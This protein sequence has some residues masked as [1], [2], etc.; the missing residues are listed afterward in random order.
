MS[1]LTATEPII[2]ARLDKAAAKQY[3][4]GVLGLRAEPRWAGDSFEHK[5]VPVNVVACPSVL[6]IWEAIDSRNAD[7]WT[8]VLTDVDDDDLG[9]TVLAHLLDGRLIT[10]DPW[11]A[12]RGNFS[13]TTI[14]PALYRVANDRA[15]ANGLLAVLSPDSY[16]PA[17]G[18]VL[19]RDHAMTT[20]ARDV[21]KIV[22]DTGVEVDPLAILEWSRSADT[23]AHLADLRARGGADLF[24]ATAAWLGSR[25]GLLSQ[26]LTAL[27]A[28]GRINEL[29]PLGVVAGLFC[30]DDNTHAQALGMFLGR[31]GLTNLAPAGLQAWYTSAR[32]LVTTALKDPQT[33]LAAAASI[34]NEL[35]I[36]SAAATSDL[37]PQGLDARVAVLADALTEALPH[38]APTDPDAA[39]ITPA[40]R[41]NIET[42]W[43][44]VNR[45]FLA[46]GSL[47]VD[48]FAG[49]IRLVRWLA[50]PV[51]IATE[52]REATACYVIRDSW[53][54]TALTKA[55]RGAEQPVA[56]AAL[57]AVIDTVAARR[58]RHDRAFARA[59][60]DAHTPALPLIENVLREVVV[61]IARQTPTL[62]LVID[63]LSVA[64]ANDLVAAIQQDGWTEVSA[65][66]R[67]GSAL[68]V[69]PTLTQRSR[70]SLLCG[71]LREGA[72]DVERRGFLSLIR[73]THLEATGGG[74]DPIFHKAALDAIPSGASLATDVANAVADTDHRPLVAAV[75]NYVD[76]T[77]HHT[78][79]GGT[80]WTVGAITHLRALLGAARSAGRAVVITSDH[81]H[82]IEYGTSAKVNRAN[83]Y[84]QRAHGDFAHVDPGR[85]VVVEGPRVL[86]DTHKV[87]LAVDP[88]IRYGARNAGYHGG[89]APAEAIVPVLTFVAGQLPAWAHQVA[90]VEPGWWYAGTPEAV[91]VIKKSSDAPSLFDVEEPSRVN[92]LPAKVIGSKVYAAQFKLA[93]RIVVTDGQIKALLTELLAAGAQELTLAQAAAALGVATAG[94]NGALMQAKRVLDVEGYEVLAVGG[95][96]VKLDE[97]A[98]RE[99]FRVKP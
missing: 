99:Q 32:G 63:A 42:Q 55:R 11:D 82:L 21:L 12:L 51:T 96:V 58:A 33:V 13:A 86:T 66:G 16:T 48:A 62:L 39:L 73:D 54:D 19:T 91:T 61:P 7:G 41:A 28:A 87:V 83:T 74:P 40:D 36:G 75:L 88:A 64:A 44:E 71:E 90:A 50:T 30:Q 65:D 78:D 45:H 76:D 59:L 93:G 5:G 47:T 49:A 17:P 8:V 56:A 37:L 31:Y 77:L 20:V 26:P 52:L 4:R 94:V 9:D 79:P 27:L 23:P 29:V 69:L 46:P 67:R 35:G 2:R 89:G 10:P 24:D 6:A 1:V 22:K 84:G 15:V 43:A 25:A 68:A 60:A 81:G 34:A 80:D 72:D 95:G 3:R 53:V 85:E 97:A 98:L 18:G 92:P 14:E 70:C 38:P 57:R